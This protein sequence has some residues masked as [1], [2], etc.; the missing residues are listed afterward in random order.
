MGVW[1][2]GSDVGAGTFRD[3]RNANKEEERGPSEGGVGSVCWVRHNRQGDLHACVDD[4]FYI[5]KEQI[6]YKM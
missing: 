1:R 3:K 2:M 4:G 5:M 6:E